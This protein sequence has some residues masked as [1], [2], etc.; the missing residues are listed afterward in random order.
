MS[1]GSVRVRQRWL[2]VGQGLLLQSS[3]HG[4]E[5]R[6][7]GDPRGLHAAVQHVVQVHHGTAQLGV[8]RTARAAETDRQTDSQTGGEGLEARGRHERETKAPTVI[9]EQGR[10][11]A[12]ASVHDIIT[13]ASAAGENITAMILP[14]IDNTSA[15]VE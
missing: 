6:E 7:G 8:V 5:V 10:I 1:A 11:A 12:V 4:R 14:L 2:V 15:C 3:V 13:A 9:S